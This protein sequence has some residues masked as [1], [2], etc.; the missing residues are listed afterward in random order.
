[1]PD[2]HPRKML[3][4]YHQKM[5]EQDADRLHEFTEMKLDTVE[6]VEVISITKAT[7]KFLEVNFSVFFVLHLYFIVLFYRIFCCK[8]L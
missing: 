4:E 5:L 6:P 3:F 2:D 8:Y 1:M 7:E